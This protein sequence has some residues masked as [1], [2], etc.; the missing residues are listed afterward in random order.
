MPAP[1]C[2]H[3]TCNVP[4]I[5]GTDYCGAHASAGRDIEAER[6][7]A[8]DRNRD[9]EA[10]AFY[11]S[12]RWK[13]ARAEK[14]ATNP[15][16]ERCSESWAVHVHHVVPLKEC[17]DD[18]KTAQT[19]LMGLC[20]PCH[21]AIEA[22]TA[23]EGTALPFVSGILQPVEDERFYYDA[24]AAEKP[25][26]FIEKY[27]R[28]YEG[29][30]AGQPFMLLDWQKQLIRTLFGWKHRAGD[31]AGLRRF[32]ELYLISAKG[33]G[34]T[35]LLTGI[36][37]FM[38]L[39]DGEVGAHVISMASTVEQAM[40]TF[41]AAKKYIA[42]CPKMANN[43]KIRALQHHIEGPKYSKWT[44]ISGE[45][46]G[47]SGP[48][49]N[50]LCASEVHEWSAGTAKGFELVAKNMV[51]RSQPLIM[52]D[53]NAGPDKSCFAWQCHER[54]V[55][56]L[57]GKSDDTT[58][59]PAIFEAPREM[60]WRSEE[61]AAAANPSLNQIL[62]FDQIR[63]ELDKG[64]PAYR[65]LFLSQ[66]VTGSAKWL[67]MDEYD[68]CVGPVQASAVQ[69]APLYVGLDL[70]QGDDLC[71]AV[72][73]YPTDTAFYVQPW[74]WLPKVTADL[75]YAK[76]SIP[77]PAWGRSGAIEIIDEPTIST[78]VQERIGAVIVAVHQVH[79]ITAVC[80]DRYFSSNTIAVIEAAGIECRRIGQ[81]HGISPGTKELDRRI[82]ERSIIIES[83][84]VMR[85]CAENAE[86][87]T[88]TMQNQWPVK[89]NAKG[90]YAGYRAAKIDG[91]TAAVTA[92]TEAR[93][94]TFPKDSA[95]KQWDGLIAVV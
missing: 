18:Q 60:D 66:W 65:R 62:T 85:M 61:A 87:K 71:A 3:S 31:Q 19:N 76:N 59:L 39:A 48:R 43:P 20:V 2:K 92:L 94:H 77:F 41:D 63:P 56:V 90:R 51:K 35:P 21:N 68:A 33:A 64:E 26:A 52:I 70:S 95:P 54:A 14:L 6:N 38:L 49:P 30:F 11:N 84:P 16:C 1:T 53:T 82:K 9:P 46:N 69:G 88:D 13:D 45:P 47:R 44:T 32:R 73:V 89:P 22:E 57:S 79:P 67:D 93:A 36:G 27:C 83:N 10:K 17:T 28:H 5:N 15:V 25:V 42:E 7:R 78:A 86:L 37:L 12:K 29:R 72:F 74:F 40:L 23:R 81:G 75:Y 8:Y 91:I 34:K 4:A 80:F 24:A 55:A 58:L 50:C